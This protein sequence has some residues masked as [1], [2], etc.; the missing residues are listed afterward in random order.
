MVVL[1]QGPPGVGKTLLIKALVQHYTR[2][3]VANP[4]GPVTLVAGK[5]RR[6]TFVE[7]PQVRYLNLGCFS[8]ASFDL[9]CLDSEY[10]IWGVLHMSLQLPDGVQNGASAD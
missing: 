9:W 3:N 2:Q 4:E 10:F 1:V 8:S 7:C 5:Q 6:I